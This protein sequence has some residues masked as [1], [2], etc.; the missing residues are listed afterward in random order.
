MKLNE[1]TWIWVES[2]IEGRNMEK[3][4]KKRRK[5]Y[6]LHSRLKD[7]HDAVSKIPFMIAITISWMVM[8]RSIRVSLSLANIREK[9]FSQQHQ[10]HVLISF[11]LLLFAVIIIIIDFIFYE[12]FTTVAF[13]THF[14]MSLSTLQYINNGIQSFIWQELFVC[15]V[16]KRSAFSSNTSIG[17]KIHI[18]CEIF[19]GKVFSFHEK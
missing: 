14:A 10:Q 15:R 17:A 18:Y 19:A 6:T 16:E 12:C 3:E 2:A 13:T 9:H 7:K 8:T 4:S 11:L 5:I 1:T